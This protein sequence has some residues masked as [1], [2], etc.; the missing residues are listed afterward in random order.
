MSTR[1][2]GGRED[3]REVGEIEGRSEPRSTSLER[4]EDG[5]KSTS[6]VVISDFGD[7]DTLQKFKGPLSLS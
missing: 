1:E 7:N 6:T 5:L 3:G 2:A 4:Q